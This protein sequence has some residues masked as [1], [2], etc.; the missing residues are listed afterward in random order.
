M[1]WFSDGAERRNQ[2]RAGADENGARKGIS[3][4]RFTEN[5]CREDRIKH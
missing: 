2:Q 1:C 3:G 5:E 4:K